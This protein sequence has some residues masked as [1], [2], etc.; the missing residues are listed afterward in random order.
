MGSNLLRILGLQKIQ[1]QKLG[2]LAGHIKTVNEFLSDAIKGFKDLDFVKAVGDALP[3]AGAVGEALAE[4]APPIKFVVRLMEFISKEPDPD[5]L[6]YL[7]CTIAYQRS[8]EQAVSAIGEPTG[9]KKPKG[10]DTIKKVAE[11]IETIE[12]KK[13]D[14]KRLTFGEALL[15][16]FVKDADEILLA[17]SEAVGYKEQRHRELQNEVHQRFVMNLKTLMSHGKTRQRF[18]PLAQRMTL[19]SE[20]YAATEALVQHAETQRWTF[21]E[22]PV[23]GKEPFSLAQVYVDIDCGVLRWGEIRDSN[24]DVS[25]REDAHRRERIDP[26]SERYGGR[27]SLARTILDFIADPKFG[28]A[29]VI[30]GVAGTGKSAF[31]LWLCAELVRRGLRPIRVMLRDLRLDRVL[32]ISEALAKAVRLID[33]FQYSESSPYPKPDDLFNNGAIF[34]ERIKF[35]KAYICPYVL[36]L[37]GWD[38]LSISVSEGFKVRLDRMLEQVRTEYLHN[39]DVPIRVILAGR[40]SVEISDSPFLLKRT[41]VLTLRP[42]TPEQLEFFFSNLAEATKVPLLTSEEL[43]EWRPFE[44]SAIKPVIEQYRADFDQRYD[45]NDDETGNSVRDVPVL[46]GSM[47]VLGLPL[48]AHLAAHLLTESEIDVERLLNNPTSLYRSLVDLTCEKAGKYSNG[49]EDVESQFKLS[50]GRLRDLLRRTATAMTV[51]GQESISFEELQLRVAA[52]ASDFTH[53]VKVDTDASDLSKLMISY[54]FKGGHSELG[55]EFLHK[56]FRE[57]LFAEGI[58]EA[59]KGYGR[60]CDRKSLPERSPYWKDFDRE[61]PRYS[62]SRDLCS[63]LAPQWLSQEIVV[64]VEELLYWEIERSYQGQKDS[65]FEKKSSVTPLKKDMWESVRDGLVDVWDWWCEGIH[66]RPQPQYDKRQ[67]IEFEMTY[68][69]DLIEWSMPQDLDRGGPLPSPCRSVTV[70]SHIGD[71]VFRLSAFIHFHVTNKQGWLNKSEESMQSVDPALQWRDLS[72]VG[73]GPRR[74]QTM[75]R[76]DGNTWLLFA[77]SGKSQIYF[78]NYVARINSAGWRPAGLFP[79]GVDMKGVDLR[80]VDMFIPIPQEEPKTITQ[81]SYANLS[82]ANVSGRL[83]YRHNFKNVQA[84]NMKGWHSFFELADMFMANLS[85]ARLGMAN[86]RQANL[87]GADLSGADLIGADLRGADLSGAE[88]RRAKFN[89]RQL[90]VA[91]NIPKKYS[92]KQKTPSGGEKKSNLIQK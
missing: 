85:L 17:C 39:Q 25:D 8:V 22:K 77:P 58:V 47:E 61:D 16:P 71:G 87:S 63:M 49:I 30:Q 51:H 26:F 65:D 52:K 10:Q 40:P 20:E 12:N 9:R 24:A 46:T 83:F 56:S 5:A 42:L 14:F 1:R 2:D 75:I 74:Y 90:A 54:Y 66:L 73:N 3:W 29:V 80:G 18:A 69:A 59:L 37:D 41:P 21:E 64:H 53:R 32:P 45:K 89:Q 23:F 33:E 31:T 43:A 82:G 27:Q 36:I 28:D 60:K 62:L 6:A 38:E 35:G 15:H 67:N 4:A 70:D 72:E 68:A 79:L 48:L 7:A 55:C 13:Y 84:E 19:G 76:R 86:L 44:T 81:W 78:T 92:S 91:R 57:Y 34:K 50:G 11:K 88:L